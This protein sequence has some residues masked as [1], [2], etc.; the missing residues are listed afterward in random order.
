VELQP[1]ASRPT[2]DGND[3]LVVLLILLLLKFSKILA[4]LPM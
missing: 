2:L 4:I 3:L 1:E